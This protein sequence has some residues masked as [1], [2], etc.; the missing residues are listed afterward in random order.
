MRAIPPS[1]RLGSEQEAADSL[2]PLSGGAGIAQQRKYICN[3]CKQE[4]DTPQA[5]GSHGASH[6]NR[7]GC[8]ARAKEVQRGG[9]KRKAR[10]TGRSSG[11]TS[12]TGEQAD[13]EAGEEGAAEA[14]TA[15]GGAVEATSSSKRRRRER[16]V[17]LNLPPVSS[18]DTGSLSSSSAETVLLSYRN[19]CKTFILV[20][21]VMFST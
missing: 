12:W 13:K 4:F 8:Y 18:P 20:H 10:R 1:M 5:R 19:G 7:K 16:P 21:V 9:P 6:R 17:D 3:G 15:S 2:L 14:P 11:E